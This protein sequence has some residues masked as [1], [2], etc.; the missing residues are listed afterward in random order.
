[1]QRFQYCVYC[2]SCSYVPALDG[3][4]STTTTQERGRGRK[5]VYYCNAILATFGPGSWLALSSGEPQALMYWI[6]LGWIQRSH[7]NIDIHCSFTCF[8]TVCVC[9][10]V[11]A[12]ACVRG[13][14]SGGGH[15]SRS[16]RRQTPWREDYVSSAPRAPS[17]PGHTWCKQPWYI[18]HGTKHTFSFL[19]AVLTTHERPTD[20]HRV[21]VSLVALLPHLDTPA[22]AGGSKASPKIQ[23]FKI[24]L[25]YRYLITLLCT[26][27][28]LPHYFSQLS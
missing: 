6:T 27:H 8:A 24:S 21:R 20:R 7:H 3:K 13:G 19:A 12:C 18:V 17:L 1:M 25:R 14:G 10:C 16:V 4:K 23:I 28:D 9:K 5:K 2:S 15:G 22:F 26:L 11:C